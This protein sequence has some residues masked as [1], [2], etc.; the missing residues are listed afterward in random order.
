MPRNRPPTSGYARIAQAEEEEEEEEQF[1]SDA[2]LAHDDYLHHQPPTILSTTPGTEYAPI[3]PKR[4]TDRMHMPSNSSSPGGRSRRRRTN[5]GVDI[6]AINLRLERWAEEIKEKFKIRRVKGKSTE[7]EHLEIYSSVFQAPEGIRP[8]TKKSLDNYY[9]EG[10]ERL[11]KVEFDDMVESVQTAIELG[12]HP[13]LISQGSSGSY[14]ARNSSGKVLG[15]FKPKDEEPYANKNP[16]W[17]KWI[18]RNL[19]PFAFGRAMLIPNLSY[20]SEA[21]AYLLDCQLR[22]N[23]VPY[24]DVV[25]LSSKSFHYDFWERRAYWKKGRALPEKAGSFQVFLK[26]YKGATEFFREHPWPDGSMRSTGPTLPPKRRRKRRWAE[27]CRPGSA[28]LVGEGEESDEDDAA[29][30]NSVPNRVRK[31]FWTEGLQQSFREELEKLVILDYIMRNTDRGTDNWMIRIDTSKQ[32]AQLVMDSPKENGHPAESADADGYPRRDDLMTASTPPTRER[33][34]SHPTIHLGAIDNSLSWPWKHPDAWRSYPFGWLFLP[35]SLIGRPFSPATRAH[36]LPLLTSKDWWTDTQVK[37]RRCFEQDEGFEEKMFARQIAVMK[38]QT[39][40]VVECLKEE[41]QGP[42]ELCRRA[43]VLVWDDVVE[44]PVARG[45]VRG[46]EEMRRAGVVDGKRERE[47]GDA[48]SGVV[49]PRK[50]DEE[51]EEMDI[52]AALASEPSRRNTPHDL[53]GMSSPDMEEQRR[54]P[55]NSSRQSSSQDISRQDTLPP[56]P[57]A[58]GTPSRILGSPGKPVTRPSASRSNT[59][60]QTRT[61]LDLPT[62]SPWHGHAH[63]HSHSHSHSERR[64][65]R[66][67]LTFR[68]RGDRDASDEEDDDGDGDEDDGDGDLG[69]AAVEGGRGGRRKRKVIV[70][71]IEMVG[72]RRPVF[73]WC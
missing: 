7:D 68:R 50:I 14:F 53:L 46:S 30:P 12:T 24:T 10:V 66:F 60:G 16:K 69:F 41:G 26:G 55:F 48:R 40:N 32:E 3:H 36:F 13:T 8:A 62:R 71:R 20:V 45:M 72:T 64:R 1:Y 73:E 63:S 22:M 34:P 29:G 57:S 4:R 54:N 44:V 42:L 65:R 23:I 19:F 18:H 70:E 28:A 56:T 37:L 9:D 17:T 38:G 33:Q 25:S 6:K 21:A 67:S 52:S 61:S 11:S 27:D 59:A 2:D 49:K 58:P 5:S 31:E 35:V 15:V 43:K 51:E 47:G 39:W